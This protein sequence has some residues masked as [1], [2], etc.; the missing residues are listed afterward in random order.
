M[1]KIFLLMTFLALPFAQ[2]ADP[3]KEEILQVFNELKASGMIPADKAPEVEK[4]IKDLSPEQL[5]KLQGHARGIAS[6]TAPAKSD[7]AVDAAL[8]VDMDSKEFHEGEEEVKK[9]FQ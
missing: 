6:K 9:M 7:S 1:L 8:S 5:G 3:S 2:A 4:M